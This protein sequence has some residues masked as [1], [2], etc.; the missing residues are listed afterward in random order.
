MSKTCQEEKST[1]EGKDAFLEQ[2]LR[3]MYRLN[4]KVSM[5]ES[6]TGQ[7]SDGRICVAQRISDRMKDG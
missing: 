5:G 7:R 6:S 2:I 3:C 4:D 1:G